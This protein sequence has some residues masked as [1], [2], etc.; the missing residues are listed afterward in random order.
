M[1]VFVRRAERRDLPAIAEIYNY[2]VRELTASFDTE[3][4]T[5]ADRE[6]WFA[7]HDDCYPIY[8]AVDGDEV[9]GWACLS[10][11]SERKAYAHTVEDSVY[12][13][14]NHWR[15]GVGSRLLSAVMSAARRLGYHAVIARIAGDA[16]ASV[17]LHR[18]FGFT[19]VGVMR[20]VGRKFGRWLD[21]IIME[22]LL[23]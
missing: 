4:R 10:P 8:V 19:E 20:E 11:F 7:E 21:V 6:H 13:H 15:C 9:V 18:R 12:V 14:P 3:E 16:A 1:S 22:A 23:E 2:A 17:A 5:L